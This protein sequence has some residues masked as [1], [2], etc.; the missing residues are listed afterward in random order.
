MDAL[1]EKVGKLSKDQKILLIREFYKN[2]LYRYFEDLVWTLDEYDT[3]GT[4]IKKYPIKEWPYLK[5]IIDNVHSEKWLYIWKSRQIM[6]TWTILAYCLWILLFHPGKKIAIQSKKEKDAN[7]LL[8]R[9]QVIYDRL[10]SWKPVAEWSNCHI[11]C[12]ENL[13][14]AYG[15]PS[16]GDQMRQYSFSFIFSDE[17]GFQDDLEL[18]FGAVKPI[19]DA[20]GR[21]VACTTPPREKNFAY[22]LLKNPL[23]KVL[24]IHYSLRPDRGESWVAKAKIGTNPDDW[25]REY[26]LMVTEAGARRIFAPFVS[27]LHINQN[28]IYS[29]DLTLF[30]IWDFGF[31]RPAVLFGQIDQQDRGNVLREV[32]GKD[33]LIDVFADRIVGFTNIHFPGATIQDICDPAGVA[34]GD[35]VEKTSIQILNSKH[36][37]PRYCKVNDE[38]GFNIIR[39]KL[40]YDVGG[41]KALQFHPMVEILIDA[42]LFGAIYGRD[43]ITPHGDGLDETGNKEKD[44][45]LHLVDC[46]K[47][48][49]AN[50]YTVRGDK[51]IV[52]DTKLSALKN[53]AGPPNTIHKLNRMGKYGFE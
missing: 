39:K 1:E 37:H 22:S 45:Y 35:K 9:M 33:E 47:Y 34:V 51:K 16:G 3:T 13:S 17:I 53:P 27:T 29:K 30:R 19:V 43:G 25:N 40:T 10:P 24:T 49:L 15:V 23:F 38:E 48:W 20:G 36:I 50:I 28:L 18:T 14:D 11:E 12:K 4:P 21:F 6:A 2:N 5:N 44:Y 26:E 8:K 42:M 46:L 32:L 7:E 31:H 41:R 52:D